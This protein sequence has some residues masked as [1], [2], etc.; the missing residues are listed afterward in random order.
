MSALPRLRLRKP[1]LVAVRLA[2]LS[3]LLATLVLF[4]PVRGASVQTVFTSIVSYR[5]NGAPNFSAP[6]NES[7]WSQISW[8]NVSLVASV[9]P[10]GGKTPSVLVRSANDGFNIYVLFRWKDAQGPSYGNS[11]ELFSSGGKLWP[12]YPDNT[13]NPA[14]DQLFFNSTYYYQDRVAILWFLGN[15]T[16]RDQT[17]PQMKLGTNGAISAGT[18]NI[19]RRKFAQ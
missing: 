5:V 4:S 2:L 17:A 12:L 11:S 16:Q 10:G 18:A 19:M 9:S 1:D 15:Q 14:A 3:L 7:F 13:T 6:G 8:I